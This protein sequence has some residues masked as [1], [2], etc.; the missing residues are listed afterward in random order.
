M[1]ADDQDL[2]EGMILNE[3]CYV[4]SERNMV[5]ETLQN[6]R[7]MDGKAENNLHDQ[8]DQILLEGFNGQHENVGL[9]GINATPCSDENCRE[10]NTSGTS[11]RDMADN[12]NGSMLP[13]I[14]SVSRT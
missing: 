11:S 9:D 4:N 7:L 14:I 12:L 3:T 10:E 5:S 2:H 8:N 1:V 13:D 6:T